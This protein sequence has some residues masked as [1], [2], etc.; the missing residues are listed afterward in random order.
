[1]IDEITENRVN[2]DR[3]K[4]GERTYVNWRHNKE[5]IKEGEK[6]V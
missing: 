6:I 4:L 1:M 5:E 2:K 3:R